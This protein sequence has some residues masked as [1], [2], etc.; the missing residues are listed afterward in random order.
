[1]D[2]KEKEARDTLAYALKKKLYLYSYIFMIVFSLVSLLVSCLGLIIDSSLEAEAVKGANIVL[3][4]SIGVSVIALILI[5][6]LS[7]LYF[8]N[9][10]DKNVSPSKIKTVSFLKCAIRFLN[11]CHG[12]LLLIAATQNAGGAGK[13]A[14]SFF[15]IYGIFILVLEGLMF[16]YSLWMAAWIKENPERYQTPVFPKKEQDKVA[17]NRHVPEE[18]APTPKTEAKAIEEDKV[19]EVP[20]QDEGV[21]LAIGHEKKTRKKSTKK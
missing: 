16:L 10:E 19:I 20:L 4:V 3:Y 21:P 15:R 8:V 6:W 14:N 7:A 2:E 17:S 13:P 9:G 5:A 18:K 11:M 1:M 12:L